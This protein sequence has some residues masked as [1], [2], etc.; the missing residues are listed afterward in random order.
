MNALVIC[1][2]IGCGKIAIELIVNALC[3]EKN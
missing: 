2:A 1:L 3:L